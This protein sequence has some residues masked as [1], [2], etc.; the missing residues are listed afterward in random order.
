[1]FFYENVDG[2]HIAK[3]RHIAKLSTSQ[4]WNPQGII[5]TKYLKDRLIIVGEV[6]FWKK[7]LRIKQPNKQITNTNRS[8]KQQRL[9][10]QAVANNELTP[11]TYR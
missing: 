2:R 4:M 8:H 11:Y 3:D 6:A 9:L 7:S 10:K 5:P 1:M